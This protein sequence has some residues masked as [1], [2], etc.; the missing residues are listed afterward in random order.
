[1]VL[2]C[3]DADVAARISA[4]GSTYSVLSEA[5]VAA[6]VFVAAALD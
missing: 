6:P 2:R 1:M 5:K 3:F 4:A